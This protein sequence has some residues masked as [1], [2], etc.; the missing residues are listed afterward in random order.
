MNRNHRWL[1]LGLRTDRTFLHVVKQFRRYGVELRIVSIEALLAVYMKGGTDCDKA[2]RL[3]RKRL[4]SVD[5]VYHRMQ[6]ISNAFESPGAR[7]ASRR[8]HEMIADVLAA[9]SACIVINRPR[10]EQ[11]NFSKI[12]HL[13][14]FAEMAQK[15]GIQIPETI[16]TNDVAAATTW[17]SA[18]G[19]QV[20]TKGASS[21]K[22]ICR[23]VDAGELSRVSPSGVLSAPVLLQ[24]YIEGPDLRVHT[25]GKHTVAELIA[26]SAIDYRFADRRHVTAHEIVEAPRAIQ[27][28]C[29]G[30][31]RAEGLHVS[32]IDFKVSRDGSFYFLEMNSMPAF[33]GYD[34]RSGGAISRA[35]M[36]I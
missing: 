9:E 21:V 18:Q 32:G 23:L 11:T 28:F 36:T 5:R 1:L 35:L 13:E 12:V 7:V 19:C 29:V 14:W 20:I 6:D 2:Q 31:N 26:S 15:H 8:C 33:K 3:L 30:L 27:E 10:A 34:I 25:I 22:S 16:V 24:R 17:I 4:D